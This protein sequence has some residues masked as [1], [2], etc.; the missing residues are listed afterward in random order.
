VVAG[1]QGLDLGHG[2][3]GFMGDGAPGAFADDQVGFPS[4]HRLHGLQQ[5]DAQDGAAGAADADHQAS[6]FIHIHGRGTP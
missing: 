5:F 1:G 6:G 4:G 3:G 2:V